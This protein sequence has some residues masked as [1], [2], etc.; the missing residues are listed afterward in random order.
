MRGKFLK[1]EEK[2]VRIKNKYQKD[3]KCKKKVEGGASGRRKIWRIGQIYYYTIFH[4]P[5]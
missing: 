1:E 2:N 4:Y 5:F 3:K